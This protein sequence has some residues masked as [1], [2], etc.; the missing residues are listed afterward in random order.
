MPSVPRRRPCSSSAWPRPASVRNSLRRHRNGL[1]TGERRQPEILAARSNHGRERVAPESRVALGLAGQRP[2]RSQSPGAARDVPRYAVDG[3]R[4]ASTPSL[5]SDRWRRSIPER[6]SRAGGSTLRTGSPD[7]PATLDSCTAASPTARI[8]DEERLLVGTGDAYLLS[9]DARNGH[10]DARFGD[11]G[12]VDLMAGRRRR[13]CA[14]PTTPFRPR[15]S[16]AAVSSW[17]GPASTTGRPTRSGRAVTSP[18]TTC[19]PEHGCGRC[20][21]FRKKESSGPRTWLGDSSSYTGS[22]NVW[23]NMS[24]DEELGL[25]L[26]PVRHADRRLLRRA[27]SRRQP[28]RREPRR[29]STHAPAS[30]R[31]TSRGSITACGTTI[32]GGATAGRHHAWRAARSKPSRR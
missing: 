12:K 25:R 15:R 28:L 22:T 5:L 11:G 30:G 21:R 27:S 2:R 29:P 32:A 24:A 6:A 19:A 26:P 16:S 20:N 7:A 9:I 23:T 3:G 14:R 31:G 17:W 18:A 8:G 4:R 13:P 10:P 1:T